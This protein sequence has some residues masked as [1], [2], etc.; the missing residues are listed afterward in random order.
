MDLAKTMWRFERGGTDSAR[1]MNTEQPLELHV[2]G[3]R[4]EKATGDTRVLGGVSS[5]GAPK[6]FGPSELLLTRGRGDF[7][8]MGLRSRPA[9]GNRD[10]VKVPGKL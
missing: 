2:L 10:A 5:T 4:A 9:P 6:T 3:G 7:W 1:E 8:G